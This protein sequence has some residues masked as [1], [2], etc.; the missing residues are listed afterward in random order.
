M[1]RTVKAVLGIAALGGVVV[2]G[3]MGY[4]LYRGPRMKVQQHVRAYQAEMPLPPAG[5]VATG[6]SGYVS[7]EVTAAAGAA[8]EGTPENIARG[9]AYYGQYCLFCHGDGGKGDGP[10]GQGYVPAAPADLTAPKTA[11]LSPAAL[12]RAML[13]GT[14]HAP[15]LERVVRPQYR[16]YLA[17]YV[18]SLG[19]R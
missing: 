12:H 9:K 10:V 4:A 6:P 14:G 1:T 18:W 19:K 8:A 13:T 15:V 7:A 17:A 2:A 3:L 16:K 5:S 11:G